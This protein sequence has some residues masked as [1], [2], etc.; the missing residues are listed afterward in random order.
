MNSGCIIIITL[1]MVS[2]LLVYVNVN[3]AKRQKTI[4]GAYIDV[5]TGSIHNFS[6]GL[7][8][9]DGE[10]MELAGKAAKNY[11][12]NKKTFE[13]RKLIPLADYEREWVSRKIK[14]ISGWY[15]V[16]NNAEMFI[17][18][19][20]STVDGFI[21]FENGEE[22]VLKGEII[23]SNIDLIFIIGDVELA[24]F[25]NKNVEYDILPGPASFQ[26]DFSDDIVLTTNHDGD[27]KSYT[28]SSYTNN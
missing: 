6:P 14:N 23:I 3:C 7:V 19:N 17:S 13:K 10:P 15:K 26:I 18:T 16:A 27:V 22:C 9:V 5:A 8:V 25:P 20:E 24:S 11:N 28:V 12:M 4:L 2:C 1:F 21:I